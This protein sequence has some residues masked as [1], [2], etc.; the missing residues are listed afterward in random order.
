MVDPEREV[1][2]RFA[3]NIEGL[4]RRRGM[5]V[6]ELAERSVTD[7]REVREILRG[8]KDVLY[9]TIALLAGAL[10]VN[11]GELFRGITWIP[12]SEDDPGKYAIDDLEEN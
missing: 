1:R 3:A 5:S 6:R 7:E 2:E 10:G 12:P 9:G 8:D 4:R 11:P